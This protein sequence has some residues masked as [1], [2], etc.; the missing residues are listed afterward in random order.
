[1]QDKSLQSEAL[2]FARYLLNKKPNLRETELY[3]KTI[4]SRALVPHE[5]DLKLLAFASANTWSIGFIDS[6]LALIHP[7]AEFRMRLHLMFAILETN[8]EYHLLFLTQERKPLYA[9][10]ILLRLLRAGLM[11][12]TG[13]L[14]LKLI[15]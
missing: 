4:R 12:I 13:C 10:R 15:R 7:G 9:L 14:L 5:R 3:E 2:F 11:G 6:G 1:M 8:P